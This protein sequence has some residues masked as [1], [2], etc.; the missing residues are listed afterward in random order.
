MYHDSLDDKLCAECRDS[1]SPF[2]MSF[3]LQS[4]PAPPAQ[5][6]WRPRIIRSLACR[7]LQCS[8]GCHAVHDCGADI[9]RIRMANS[10]F[11]LFPLFLSRLLCSFERV[12]DSARTKIQNVC[13]FREER[14]RGRWAGSARRA[15]GD[16][17]KKSTS[18]LRYSFRRR[19]RRPLGAGKARARE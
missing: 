1:S 6:A 18:S 4:S 10:F 15:E 12:K 3:R 13:S 19:R 14:E 5:C 17:H 2:T 16:V 9:V 7:A 11:P 8:G